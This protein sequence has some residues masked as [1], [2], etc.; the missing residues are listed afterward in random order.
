MDVAFISYSSGSGI[1]DTVPMRLNIKTQPL[2]F[3]GVWVQFGAGGVM[4]PHCLTE[5]FQAAQVQKLAVQSLPGHLAT[6]CMS[7]G[8]IL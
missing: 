6:E 7:T 5:A 1:V 4:D 3:P 2:P 8:S